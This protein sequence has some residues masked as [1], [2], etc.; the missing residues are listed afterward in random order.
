MKQWVIISGLVFAIGC[1]ATG[2]AVLLMEQGKAAMLVPPGVDSTVAADAAALGLHSFAVNQTQGVLYAADG[3]RF[4]RMADSLLRLHSWPQLDSVS[5]SAVREA[6]SHFNDG[7]RALDA[8]ET[9]AIDS[10]R[11]LDLLMQAAD[12]FEAA[13]ESDPFDAESRFWLGR[14]YEMQSQHYDI[15]NALQKA[16]DIQQKLVSLHQNRHAFI[17][18][19][20]RLYDRVNT[21]SA[22]MMAGA[23]WE[24]AARVAQDDADLGSSPSITADSIAIFGYLS[25]S[26]RAYGHGVRPDQVL[27]VIGEAAPWATKAEDRE[28]L[29][30]ERQWVMWDDGNLRTR[31]TFDRIMQQLPQDPS[32][33]ISDLENLLTEVKTP[34]ARLDVQHRISLVLYTAGQKAK[35]VELMQRLWE[36]QAEIP[37]DLSD[38]LRAD[39]AVMVYNLAQQSRQEG[40]LTRALAYLLQCEQL[41]VTLSARAALQAAQLLQNN[42]EAALER[43]LSAEQRREDLDREDQRRLTRYIVELYRRLGKREKARQY[44]DRLGQL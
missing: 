26:M 11:A 38:R 40:N 35:A 7:A 31:H 2:P 24:R 36:A 41:N 14:V 13:L 28:F 6:T 20:A 1:G 9:G 18:Q 25:R 10:T 19:L 21:E 43:A 3:H 30:S 39:Y 12:A 29:E 22:S 17:G 32:Q 4:A 5:S 15:Q 27:R 23:L 37:E 34:A 8:L 44:Y 16:I 33:V 42:P